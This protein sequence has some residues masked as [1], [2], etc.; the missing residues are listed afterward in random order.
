MGFPVEDSRLRDGEFC[1]R[2]PVARTSSEWGWLRGGRPQGC[3]DVA[4][5]PVVCVS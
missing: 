3:G 1:T 2:N 4:L 5:V